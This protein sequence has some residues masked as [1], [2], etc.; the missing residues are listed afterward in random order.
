M[1]AYQGFVIGSVVASLFWAL[2]VNANSTLWR[3]AV[4]E[5]GYGEYCST[6]GIW[7]FKGEC[8]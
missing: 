5:R 3:N 1:T 4:T 2:I 7:T 6:T 8:E